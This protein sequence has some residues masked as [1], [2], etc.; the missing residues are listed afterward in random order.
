M[1]ARPTSARLLAVATVG[2]TAPYTTLR[3][4][5]WSPLQSSRHRDRLGRLL[6]PSGAVADID[7]LLAART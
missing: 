4:A 6:V 7:G 5:T 1:A 2:R 3:D